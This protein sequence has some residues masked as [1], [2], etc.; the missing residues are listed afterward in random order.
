MVGICFKNRIEVKNSHAKGLEIVKFFR[1][2]VQIP[3]EKI[4]VENFSG[5]IRTVGRK[6]AP[7]LAQDLPGTNG[8]IA[9]C[10]V[11]T[12]RKY[13]IHDAT[14]HPCGRMICFIEYR[15]LPA[16]QA[17]LR[18]KLSVAQSAAAEVL[19]ADAE[20]VKVKSDLMKTKRHIKAVI[21]PVHGQRR[22]LLSVLPVNKTCIKM[23]RHCFRAHPVQTKGHRTT[24]RESSRAAFTGFVQWVEIKLHR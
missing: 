4:I 9:F 7:I 16:C 12:V 21:R 14:L 24:A 10:P 19:V 8:I 17:D 3:S 11:K 22:A 15:D 5:T 23:L 1:N 13:L 6:S 18:H 2:S 20:I